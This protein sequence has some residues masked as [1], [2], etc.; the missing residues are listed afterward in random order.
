MKYKKAPCLRK[1]PFPGCGDF[2]SPLFAVKNRITLVFANPFGNPVAYF[3]SRVWF[4]AGNIDGHHFRI[5]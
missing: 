3:G 1:E 5:Q 2:Q 4:F